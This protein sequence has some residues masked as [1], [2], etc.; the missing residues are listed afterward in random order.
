MMITRRLEIRQMKYFRLRKF[1]IVLRGYYL[2]SGY[3]GRKQ[4]NNHSA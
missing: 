3:L 2:R 4:K 1:N